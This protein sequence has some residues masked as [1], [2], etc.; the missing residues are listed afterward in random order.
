[1]T[2]ALTEAPARTDF[3]SDEQVGPLGASGLPD[4]GTEPDTPSGGGPL[5]RLARRAADSLANMPIEGYITLG[6]VV[7]CVVFV[8]VQLGPHNV[9]SDTTPAGGDMGAH[10]WGPAYLRDH[11]LTSGR[12]T[13]WSPDWYAGFPAYQFYMVLP[14]LLI[15]L[16]SYVLPYGVAF[17]LVAIS[18]V[19]SL[20]VCAWAFGRL[21]RLPFPIPPLLAVAATMYLFDR[22]FSI[23]GGNI[24]ST[25]AGEFAFS[26]SLSFALL[27]LGVVARGLETGKYRGWAAVLLAL[28][29]LCH[30]IPLFF[31]LAGTAVWFVLYLGWP[32]LRA[33]VAAVLAASSVVLGVLLTVGTNLWHD[34]LY[35]GDFPASL[36]RFGVITAAVAVVLF[37]PAAM[38][39]DW[40]ARSGRCPST[41]VTAT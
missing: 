10:V 34:E 39:A 3:V 30:L 15:A 38:F 31:A 28:T 32:R 35:F 22:S 14:S 25:L 17:K 9:L 4:D 1:M 6:I 18:G 23:L 19:L 2:D 26:M 33:S 36:V 37:V 27:Y 5:R 24:P 40:P 7:A 21:S 12:L 20:P 16:L 41:C 13:G 11:L 8:F 29:A